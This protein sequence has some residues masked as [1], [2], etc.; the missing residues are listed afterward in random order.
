[1]LCAAPLFPN[2]EM[3]LTLQFDQKVH[4]QEILIVVTFHYELFFLT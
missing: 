3:P 2:S 1:M 4:I